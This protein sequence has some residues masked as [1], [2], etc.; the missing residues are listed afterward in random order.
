MTFRRSLIVAAF[1]WSVLAWRLIAPAE[2]PWPLAIAAA[3]ALLSLFAVLLVQPL[4]WW[5]D[6]WVRELARRPWMRKASYMGMAFLSIL[7]ALTVLRD[8]VWIVV[9]L[10]PDSVVHLPPA[11]MR[12]SSGIV[13]GLAVLLTGWGHVQVRLGPRTVRV[14]VPIS[15]L[16]HA[17]AGFRIVQLSDV[18][19]GESVRRR[20]IERLVSR[21]NAL[22]AD[23]VAITGDLVDGPVHQLG[24]HAEPLKELD[25]RHGTYF[26]AG[27]HE[28]YSGLANWLRH[29][30]RLGFIVLMNEHRL[31][32]R[33]G[34]ALLIAGV[35]DWSALRRPQE[36]VKSTL[37]DAPE[38]AVRILLA[39]QPKTALVA[40]RD[41]HLQLSGHTH[42]GQFLPWN[43]VARW[44]HRFS[45][46]LY[47]V[48][49]MWL[50]VSRGTF[51][52]G[53]PVRV[54]AP[55]EITVLELVRAA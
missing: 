5:S 14:R 8:V 17:F 28:H 52:W 54:L 10:L 32:E 55:A 36:E 24:E 41:F 49:E 46:G 6:G 25:S 7:L 40:S 16:P 27:N 34:H 50:Y 2:L 38:E 35:D 23:L 21:V 29:L 30:K 31:I 4:S 47:K 44:V 18:H 26:V 48:G 53:P 37:D 9:S 19:I 22:D 39:H 11:V 33:E 42:G 3:L 1:G 43:F 51:Y 20:H 15:G 45:A 12:A 13:F